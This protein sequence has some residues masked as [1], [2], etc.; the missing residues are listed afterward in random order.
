[1]NI[2]I[3]NLE[4]HYPNG[5][6]RLAIPELKIQSGSHTA[7]VGPSGSGKTTLLQLIGGILSPD[8][9][10]IYL[11]STNICSLSEEK[12]RHFRITQIGYVFQGFEL[13]E[14]LNGLDNIL[15]PCRIHSRLSLNQDVLNRARHLAAA[16]GVD[17][18]LNEHPEHLS[19]GE[20]QRL[21][22]C[23]ALLTSPG[24]VLAD[25]PTGNLDPENKRKILHLLFEQA[26]ACR[27]TLIMV[28]H[29]HTLLDAFDAC[30]DFMQFQQ[31]DSNLDGIV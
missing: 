27:S 21:A 15:L 14:Y 7:F 6:F 29:D 5:A 31:R 8:R 24:I 1:M 22:I 26:E 28:T 12:R 23:R 16:T 17:H 19:Q 13:L 20:R 2:H 9:G 11:E 10:A 3:Q 30:I 4:F 25:E 18:K